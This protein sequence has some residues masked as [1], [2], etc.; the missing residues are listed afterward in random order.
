[1][2]EFD[3]KPCTTDRFDLGECS[4]WDAVRGE[5]YWI[6]VPTGRFFRAHAND[7]QVNLVHTYDLNCF[8]TAVAPMENR[9][10]GWIVAADQ[11]ISFLD[12]TG[13]MRVVAE[14]EVHNVAEVRM[15]DGACDPWGNFWIGSAAGE[16][17]EGIASLY[18]FHESS[19]AELKNGNVTISNGLG[20]SPDRRTMYYVDSGPGTIHR[21]DVDEV[22]QTSNK[23][24]LAQYSG[25]R[26][27]T[28]DGLCV[29]S[30][31]AIWVAFWGGYQV[32]RYSP[33]WEL[34]AEV[35]LGTS[36]ASSC[37]IGG[38]N[39]TTLYI[40]TAKENLTP[41]T[42]ENEP[43]AGR[44]FC[45]DVKVTGLAIEPYRHTLRHTI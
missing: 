14:P 38:A 25:G 9:S 36:K 5:L 11:S 15:N 1:M 37:A 23:Q 8:L 26:E 2:E 45:V 41:E 10:E 20:W 21:F 35:N 18:R 6:D 4:R 30:E 3:A 12:E 27:G 19:G 32:R 29:D 44:L 34:L 22:G 17:T 42:L 13:V 39:G 24:L 28:P 33:A 40:T 43:D 7:T 16:K 31:G